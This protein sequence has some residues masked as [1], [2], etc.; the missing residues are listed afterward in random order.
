MTFIFSKKVPPKQPTQLELDHQRL[1]KQEQ[2][3]RKEMGKQRINQ[4]KQ[5][6]EEEDKNIRKLEKML[7][8]DKSK[9]KNSV[10]KMFHDGLDYAL[11]MCLPENID[12]MY[13][14]AKEAADA[15]ADTGREWHEDFAIATGE[16]KLPEVEARATKPNNATSKTSSNRLRQIESKYFGES[17]DEL[18]SDL[19]GVD[20]E[21]E[22]NADDVD[23]DKGDSFSDD[24]GSMESSDEAPEEIRI[25]SKCVIKH[26]LNK[27]NFRE[28]ENKSKKQKVIEPVDAN[29]SS[30]EGD[31]DVESDGNHVN[32]SYTV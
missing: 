3:L 27:Q 16:I 15:D 17:E 30:C 25:V 14:A 1:V 24:N 19:S 18:A 4:L 8:L 31:G 29:D 22:N 5:A 12:K 6:N 32:I 9:S 10:P 26:Q 2:A 13:A 21:F 7:K 11:E 20:S 23:T 28:P